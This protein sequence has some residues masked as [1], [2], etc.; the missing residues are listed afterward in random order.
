MRNRAVITRRQFVAT[1]VTALVAGRAC[2]R[3]TPAELDVAYVNGRIW[4][5]VSGAPPQTAFGTIGDRIAAVGDDARIRA[6]AGRKT[7]VI[8]LGGAFVMPG[9]VDNHTHFLRAS[10][11]PYHAIDD[12]RWA[13]TPLG[14]DRLAGSWAFRSLLDARVR[15]TFGSDW[16]VAPIGPLQGVEA[17]VLRRTI[18]G[19]NP[20]G[21]VPAQRIRVEE[22][23]TAYTVNNA[24][25]GFQD[26]RLGRIEPGF[27]ADVVVLDTDLLTTPADR[28]SHAKV[29][30]TI[31]NGA[32]RFVD[33]PA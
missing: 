25:A 13:V 4:T 14:P 11:Q 31:V 16:P 12:G 7:Q 5:G 6:L 23:L 17:A 19:A 24:Y 2:V 1:G 8:D 30:R 27:L 29:L 18:D 33:S 15:V 20:D 10:M 9:F 26:D 3:S 32:S 22:A 21:W 28:I